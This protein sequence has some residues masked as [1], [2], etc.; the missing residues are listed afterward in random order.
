MQD[1]LHLAVESLKIAI[2]LAAQH[3][4]DVTALQRVL[5]HLS[6]KIAKRRKS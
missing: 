3:G 5:H 4:A 1:D 6:P 2:N